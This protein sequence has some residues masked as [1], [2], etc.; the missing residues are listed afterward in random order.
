MAKV[1]ISVFETED[2]YERCEQPAGCFVLQ[3]GIA[4]REQCAL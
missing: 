4:I 1:S 2:R 3:M